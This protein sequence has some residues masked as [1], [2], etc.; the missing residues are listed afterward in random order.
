MKFDKNQVFVM[1]ASP[2]QWADIA[3]EIKFSMNYLWEKQELGK[4]VSYSDIDGIKKKSAVSRT[5]ILLAAFALENLIMGLII[6]QNQNYIRNGKLSKEI[7]NHKLKYLSMQIQDF[8]FS[9]D[10]YKLIEILESCIPSWGR[11]PIPGKIEDIEEEVT[12][13]IDLKKTFDSMFDRLDLF[14]Y[15]IL[16]NGWQGPHGCYLK[17]LIRPE[18]DDRAIGT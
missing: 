8:S 16:K 6:S 9:K 4:V 5:W 12:V 18:M 15:K 7:S 10:E 13:S 11:Y 17:E 1:K 14:L 2:N 3:G